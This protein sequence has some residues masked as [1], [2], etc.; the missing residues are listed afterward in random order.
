M[1]RPIIAK[2]HQQRCPAGTADSAVFSHS[3]AGSP[4]IQFSKLPKQSSIKYADRIPIADYPL[5][6]APVRQDRNHDLYP[7]GMSDHLAAEPRKLFGKYPVPLRSATGVADEV[8]DICRAAS[9]QSGAPRSIHRERNPTDLDINNHWNIFPANHEPFSGWKR[10]SAITQ[11]VVLRG[12]SNRQ[13]NQK[14][15]RHRHSR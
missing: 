3:F 7:S 5:H 8:R 2:P 9:F 12:C 15:P 10:N 14:Y 11:I 1:T 4:L 13:S 6:S